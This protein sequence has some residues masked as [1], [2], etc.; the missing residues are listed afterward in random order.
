MG[1]SKLP[2]IPPVQH[3]N[4]IVTDTSEK[5]TI[6]NTFFAEQC[7]VIRT[8]S[9]L[10][11]YQFLTNLRLDRANFDTTKILT[12]IRSLN[13]NKAH[14]WDEVSIRMVTIC[15]E[16]LV[17]PLQLIFQFSSDT[18]TFPNYWKIGN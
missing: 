1:K 14:G 11:D 9:V 12:I 3:N 5:A 4:S 2:R 6:F 16:T 18:G 7:T 15:D 8:G 17:L 10:P 13:V